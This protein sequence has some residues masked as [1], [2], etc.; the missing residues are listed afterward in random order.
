[1]RRI[2]S[3][4][5][6]TLF[7]LAGAAA[8]LGAQGLNCGSFGSQ[9]EAQAVLDADPSDPNGLDTDF[10]GIA[11]ESLVPP[12]VPP[13]PPTE[14]PPPPP[15]QAPPPPPLPTQDLYNCDDFQFQEDAQAVYDADP[16][17]PHGLDG[18]VGPTT[19]GVP[20]KACEDRPSRGTTT[21]GDAVA[22]NA[23]ATNQ[24]P[25]QQPVTAAASGQQSAVAQQN[26]ACAIY[27][28][29]EWA[30]AVFDSE[31]RANRALDPD[32]D[33]IACP[34]LPNGFAPAFWTDSIPVDVEQAEIVRVIDVSTLAV[35]FDDFPD[36][37]LVTLG[38]VSGT[39]DPDHCGDEEAIAYADW[40]L[41]WNDEPDEIYLQRVTDEQDPDDREPAYVWF[42]VNGDPYMLNHILINNGWADYAEVEDG[43]HDQEL[44]DAAEFAE[45]HNL[46]MWDLCGGFG[47]PLSVAATAQAEDSTAGDVE[48]QEQVEHSTSTAGCNVNDIAGSTVRQGVDAGSLDGRLGG[49]LASFEN[50]YGGPVDGDP[51]LEYDIPGCGT[52]FV[53]DF[54]GSTV[55]EISIFAPRGD[56]NKEYTEPDD[57]DWTIQEAMR[58][59]E[60]F[61][62]EDADFNPPI[63]DMT[64]PPPG[65]L[66]DHIEV[67]GTSQLL[68]EQVPTAAYDYIDNSPTYGGF[69]YAL[70]RTTTGD[71]SWMVI[72]L[73]IED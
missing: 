35:Q 57:A 10:D 24:Q 2:A 19:D 15:T 65:M 73:E 41:S 34:G 27:D 59:A 54:E 1:M 17:D 5:L 25:V 45:R 20:G 72:Q 67:T 32:G 28:A 33:G 42:E 64:P 29:W 71:V 6:A 70:F 46:G 13:P 12:E 37:V 4:V 66:A 7:L 9:A 49:T 23:P 8:S 48:E 3:I 40:A 30:Q 36:P 21:G 51:F 38:Q 39:Q 11:C 47:T 63:G 61:L 14:V 58:I 44:E 16:S 60:G 50:I 18:P 56:E 69:S 31:P 26:S 22:G 43:R 62:P 68:L 53:S 52:V 55:I